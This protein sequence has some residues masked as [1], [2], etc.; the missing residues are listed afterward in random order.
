MTRVVHGQLL[1]TGQRFGVVVSRFNNLISE[2][3]LAGA[4]DCLERHGV[5]SDDITVA[6]VPGAFEIPTAAHHLAASG[7]FD[8]V[9]CLGTL[10]RGA[11]PHFDHISA[12]VTRQIADLAV[13]SGVPVLYGVLT[14]DTLE[15]ALERAGSKAGN[16]GVE[17]AAAALEMVSL[18]R[19]LKRGSQK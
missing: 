11:T 5:A 16:K 14:T 10:I 4:V 19:E 7:R 12:A 8:A 9:I 6:W 17:A 18:V 15:Q 13:S 2:K 1:G 3:L